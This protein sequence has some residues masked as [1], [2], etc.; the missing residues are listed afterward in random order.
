MHLAC[1]CTRNKGLHVSTHAC[2]CTPMAVDCHGTAIFLVTDTCARK[3]IIPVLQA[4]SRGSG[5]HRQR[6]FRT[7]R[8]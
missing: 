2:R 5:R 4:G 6:T 3:S 1:R 7:C 8:R